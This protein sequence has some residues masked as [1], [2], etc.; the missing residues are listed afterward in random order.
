MKN[1]FLLLIICILKP[2]Y[3]DENL[4]NVNQALKMHEQLTGTVVLEVIPSKCDPK[5]V[6]CLKNEAE[7][8][9]KDLEEHLKGKALI[10]TPPS[11]CEPKAEACLKAEANEQKK[12]I[13]DHLLGTIK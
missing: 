4:V 11:K 7:E 5:D 9:K 12:S 6:T 2:A 10:D 8:Q 3:A 1:Y 13:E